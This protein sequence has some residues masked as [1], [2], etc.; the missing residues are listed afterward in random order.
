MSVDRTQIAGLVEELLIA[1]GE[2]PNRPG[3]RETPRR[4]A[5]WW[6]EFIDYE[7]GKVDTA[8]EAVTA[9][10][11][12]VVS[13]MRVWSLCE[14]HLLP[15]WCDVSVGYIADGKVLG[16]S[17]FARIA[18]KHAHRLQL[19]E[20]LVHGIAEEVAG[21]TGSRD[22]AV[23]AEG[24]HLCMIMRGVKTPGVMKSSVMLGAFREN[25]ETRAEFLRM[26]GK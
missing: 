7:P 22:V 23:Y 3:I 15:L 26:V 20:Q 12:V 21:L 14:H 6:G 24:Q 25:A 5:N 1:I 16:L 4:V 19:Q 8:F 17:K 13:G 18:H 9:D 10:Q 2:D 11:M